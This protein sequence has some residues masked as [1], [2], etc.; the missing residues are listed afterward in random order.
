MKPKRYRYSKI[1][2][3]IF[4][5]VGFV[6]NEIIHKEDVIFIFLKMTHKRVKCP[7]CGGRNRLLKDFYK[8]TVRDLDVGPKDCYITF[9]ENKLK[10]KCG[11]RGYEKLDFSRPYSRCTIRFEKYV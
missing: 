4:T 9:L 1:F 3:A 8:G 2:R 11:F 5:F 10:C 6:Y 7:A